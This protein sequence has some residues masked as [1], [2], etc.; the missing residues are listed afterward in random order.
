M[1][2]VIQIEWLG[3]NDGQPSEHSGRYVSRFDADAR[4]GLGQVWTTANPRVALNFNSGAEAAEFWRQTSTV[5]PVREDGKPNRPLTA[6][7]VSIY[8]WEK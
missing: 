7:T 8:D 2:F 6:F 3:G 1:A 4:D 5:K